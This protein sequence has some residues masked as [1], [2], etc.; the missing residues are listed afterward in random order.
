MRRTFRATVWRSIG[1]PPHSSCQTG[2]AYYC[3]C[4]PEDLKARRD[5]AE[6]AGDAWTYDRTCFAVV[7]RRDRAPRVAPGDPRAIRFLVPEGAHV[8]R[9]SRPRRRSSSITPTSKTSSCF[10]RTVIRPI[11]CRSSSTTSRW[12]ITHVVRGDDHISNTPEAGAA[13]PGDAA[14]RCRAFAHVPLILGSG[15]EA[16]EQAPRRDRRSASTRSRATCRRRW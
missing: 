8:I 4:R 11:T 6:A 5:A 10:D 12:Q 7:A 1:T 15:Q 16:A 13:V 2:H 14:R 3:F 9:R